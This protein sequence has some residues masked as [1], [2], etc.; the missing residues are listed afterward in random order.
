MVITSFKARVKFNP[1][2]L[3]SDQQLISPYNMTPESSIKVMRIME[4]ITNLRSYR[5]LNKF[6]S[7]A[8]YKMYG[9]QYGEYA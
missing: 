5:L 7:S 9:G 4:M 8:P 6:S 2:T 1:L 3:K